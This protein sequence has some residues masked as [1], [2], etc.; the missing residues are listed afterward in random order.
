MATQRLRG[1]YAVTPDLADTPRLVCLVDAALEGG[2]AAIQYR[3]KTSAA[4]LRDAQ[5]REL[6]KITKQHG[7]LFIVNDDPQLAR[8][9]GADGVH[10]GED[11]A[12]LAAVRGIVGEALIGVSCYN[13]VERARRLVARGADYVAFG[14]FFASSVKPEARHADV[15]L[16]AAARTLGVPIVGIGGIDAENARLLV[17]AGIDAVAVISAVFAHDDPSEVTHAARRI[18]DLFD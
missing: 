3:S 5:A 4:S 17:A 6:A 1:L 16:I 10:I 11:D 2:A 9:V 8:E 15:S 12:S 14:S 18:A 13:D 7:A